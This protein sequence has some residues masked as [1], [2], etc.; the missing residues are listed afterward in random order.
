[1]IITT[2][3]AIFKP[4]KDDFTKPND[5]NLGVIKTYQLLYKIMQLSCIK[6]LVV[7]LLTIGVRTK[8]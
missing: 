8:I 2:L 5:L 1:M 6:K 4:E 7:I 3:V